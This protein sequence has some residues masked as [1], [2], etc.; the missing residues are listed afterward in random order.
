MRLNLEWTSKS[1]LVAK[2]ADY[3]A[4]TSALERQIDN[5]VYRLYKLTYDLMLRRLDIK[6]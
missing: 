3:K 1:I 6:C 2:A 4:D 5:F